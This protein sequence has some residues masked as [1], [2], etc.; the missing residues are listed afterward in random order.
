MFG[1]KIRNVFKSR[2]QAV[3][4]SASMLLTAYCSIPSSDDDGG[5][6]DSATQLAQQ[7]AGHVAGHEAGHKNPWAKDPAAN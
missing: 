4:W 7:V 5:K 3:F 2:W 6:D 1:P